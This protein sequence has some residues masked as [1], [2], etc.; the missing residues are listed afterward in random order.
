MC[1]SKEVSLIA[2]LIIFAVCAYSYYKYV[3]K[4]EHSKKVSSNIKHLRPFYQN[5][6][7]GFLC[8]GGH[9]LSE[10]ISIATGNELIYKIGLVISIS[11]MYFFMKSLQELTHYSFYGVFFIPIIISIHGNLSSTKRC[12]LSNF[13]FLTIFYNIFYKAPTN[14]SACVA[15]I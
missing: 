4:P 7:F 6:I 12:N 5:V 9:Q 14:I 13:L 3:Y 1:Y 10:F 8:I 15:T 2:A 11:A